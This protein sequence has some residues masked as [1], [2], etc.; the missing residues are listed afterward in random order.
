LRQGGKERLFDVERFDEKGN[1]LLVKLKGVDTPEAARPFKGAEIL[2][3]RENAAPLG[4]DEYYIG[5]LRGITVVSAD[6][7]VLGHVTDI[8]EG[9]GGELVEMRLLSGEL[10]L[11]PF[12]KE[13]FGD[14]SPEEGRAVFLCRWIFE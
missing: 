3:G 1:S 7:E 13:F 12:R 8:L 6:G 5:D 10:K 9:G 14:V 4:P 2:T 11:I